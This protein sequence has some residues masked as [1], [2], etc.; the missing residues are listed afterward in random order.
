MQIQTSS[1]TIIKVGDFAEKHNNTEE[2]GLRN[3]IC[4]TAPK[5]AFWVH[6][7]NF[8][9]IATTQKLNIYTSQ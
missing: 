7:C 2:T 5:H 3:Y 6:I 4:Q 9:R 1:Q 8:L